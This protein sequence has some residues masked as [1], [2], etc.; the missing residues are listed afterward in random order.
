MFN[1]LLH[2]L[3]D[4][5]VGA[6]AADIADPANRA[7]LRRNVDA[8]ASRALGIDVTS[9]LISKFWGRIVEKAEEEIMAAAVPFVQIAVSDPPQSVDV[10][11]EVLKE[12]ASTKIDSMAEKLKQKLKEKKGEQTCL[13]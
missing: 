1:D 11:A 10:A 2:D 6:I 3:S 5:L 9:P 13:L 12:S 7:Q 4:E 8:M